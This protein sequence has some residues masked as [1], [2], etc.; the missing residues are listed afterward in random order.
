MAIFGAQD[1]SGASFFDDMFYA[2]AFFLTLKNA[3]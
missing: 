3:T 2:R 1:A